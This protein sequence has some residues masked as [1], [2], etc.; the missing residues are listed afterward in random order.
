MVRIERTRGIDGAVDIQV[1]TVPE[2][3]DK[4]DVVSGCVIAAGSIAQIIQTGAFVTLD[5]DGNWYD[6]SGS[7]VGG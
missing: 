6:E 3:P 4:G 5:D 1:S 7:V 2:L